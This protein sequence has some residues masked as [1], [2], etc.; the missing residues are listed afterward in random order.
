MNKLG[1]MIAYLFLLS[2]VILPAKSRESKTPVQQRAEFEVASVNPSES[3]RGMIGY[4]VYPGGRVVIGHSTLQR[5]IN[6]PSMFSRFRFPEAR[7][8]CVTTSIGMR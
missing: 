4:L 1:F 2:L 7:P 5:L 3:P 6:T 8:G